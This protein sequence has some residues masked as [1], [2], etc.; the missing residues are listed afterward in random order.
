MF[1]FFGQTEERSDILSFGESELLGLLTYALSKLSQE[2]KNN[3]NT[4]VP[5]FESFHLRST[6]LAGKTC[7]FFT[8]LK[9]L[10]QR[11]FKKKKKRSS[12]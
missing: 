3:Q 1:F 8:K 7:P 5:I 12:S 2:K 4:P 9:V 6:L 10:F 11:P